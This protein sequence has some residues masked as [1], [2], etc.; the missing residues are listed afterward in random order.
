MFRE[1]CGVSGER[2]ESM[3]C[4]GEP[5]DSSGVFVGC[6]GVY[7]VLA[8]VSGYYSRFI[9]VEKPDKGSAE[10]GHQDGHYR[11]IVPQR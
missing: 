4:S 7:L 1:T 3:G 11:R 8:E 10:P 6:R 9:A 2:G 5:A